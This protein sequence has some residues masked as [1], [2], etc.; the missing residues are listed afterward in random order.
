V[1]PLLCCF[2][3]LQS[4][5][6]DE[7]DLFLARFEPQ[8]LAAMSRHVA[9]FPPSQPDDT[10][11]PQYHKSSTLPLVRNISQSPSPCY[12]KQKMMPKISP[13]KTVPS[14]DNVKVNGDVTPKLNVK[15]AVFGKWNKR[16]LHRCQTIRLN[17][18]DFVPQRGKNTTLH[19]DQFPLS[20]E[21][22][23]SLSTFCFPGK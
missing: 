19:L 2:F 8:I 13:E 1:V 6:E 9:L 16:S 4:P 22:L 14:T 15:G 12:R 11:P 5:V 21:N 10:Y 3:I 18:V 17:P 7:H 20:N 23:A